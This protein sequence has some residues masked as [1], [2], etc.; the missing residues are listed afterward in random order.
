MR[1]T[2]ILLARALARIDV[3]EL[4][5]NGTVRFADIVAPLVKE[6]DFK[7]YPVSSED[8]DPD[9]GIK[10]HQGKSEGKVIGLLNIFSGLIA[11]ESLS[12]TAD[13]KMLLERLLTWGRDNIGLTYSDGLIRRW[14]YVSQISFDSDIPLLKM[15]S[16]PVN[17]LSAKTGEYVDG[18]FAEGLKYELSKIV[19]GHDP[20]V[21]QGNIASVTIEHRSNL[22]FSDNK[23]FSEAP[24]PTD[25]H[26]KFL[27]ELEQDVM[28]R[29]K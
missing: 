7:K 26:I 12:S 27:Q 23:F 29:Q 21:R 16:G 22:K 3:D 25:I 2:A 24:L 10:F 19:V 14:G 6:Y 11:L 13:S 1:I 18:L 20:L 8:F 15:L 4:N 9:K 5:L 28:E 17:D